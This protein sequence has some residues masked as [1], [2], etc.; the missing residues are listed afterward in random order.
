MAPEQWTTPWPARQVRLEATWPI[1]SS[2]VLMKTSSHASTTC[3]CERAGRTADQALRQP[4]GG[5]KGPAGDG[6]NPIARLSQG[7]GQGA[8]YSPCPDEPDRALLTGLPDIS[9][10][11][12]DHDH[13]WHGWRKKPIIQGSAPLLCL[14]FFMASHAPSMAYRRTMKDQ[15]APNM[16]SFCIYA[17]DLGV[18][19]QALTMTI[20][21]R[22][23][24]GMLNIG[25]CIS[26]GGHSGT[27]ADQ[28]TGQGMR[29]GLAW[30]RCR[31]AWFSPD[32]TEGYEYNRDLEGLCAT[33]GRPRGVD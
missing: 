19:G 20:R 25:V 11:P 33:I 23:R 4:V 15:A 18:S 6:H 16:Q 31:L 3:C 24:Q 29:M 9:L 28:S 7:D 14:Y 10:A 32:A 30:W 22:S 8:S 17:D 27:S 2:G 12:Q 13:K 21:R 5:R 26:S 1:T